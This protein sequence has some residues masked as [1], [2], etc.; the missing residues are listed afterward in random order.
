MSQN[1]IYTHTNVIAKDWRKLAQF[2]M[3]VFQCKPLYPERD[4]KG[5]W[6]DKITG[7]KD[8]HIRGIHLSLPGFEKGADLRNL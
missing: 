3:D 5:E 4:L 7:I 6:I 8:V 1:I 2:Y